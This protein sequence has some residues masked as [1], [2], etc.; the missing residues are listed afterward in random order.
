M[1]PVASSRSFCIYIQTINNEHGRL[2]PSNKSLYRA[3][4]L[5][6][7]PYHSEHHVFLRE[8]ICI[9]F[10]GV[11]VRHSC[12][13]RSTS[14]S[15]PHTMYIG[16]QSRRREMHST[17][18]TK[19]FDA[20]SVVIQPNDSVHDEMTSASDGGESYSIECRRISSLTRSRGQRKRSR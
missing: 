14:A 12:F 8:I 4:I 16:R 6:I 15:D 17:S 20:T 10:I 1:A 19:V 3:L 9:E 7:V 2:N 18:S 13:C 5:S 11:E